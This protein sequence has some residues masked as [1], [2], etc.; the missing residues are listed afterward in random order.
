MKSAPMRSKGIVMGVAELLVKLAGESG[1]SGTCAVSD[2]VPVKP[3][4]VLADTSGTSGTS[5]NEGTTPKLVAGWLLH[6]PDSDPLS[7]SF[8]PAVT[9]TKAL[10]SYPQAVAADPIPERPRRAATEAE[11]RELRGLI[12][13]VYCHETEAD[14]A[15]ALA[16]ALRDTMKALTCYRS[17]QRAGTSA[18]ECSGNRGNKDR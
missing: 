17:I 9:H 10:E 18:V 1:T 14:R 15:E 7:V 4:P 16:E 6:F 11:A 5:Q 12:E 8:C 13:A 3:A 2:A